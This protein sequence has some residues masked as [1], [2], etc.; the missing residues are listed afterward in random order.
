M[1]KE[2]KKNTV[3]Y[4]LYGIFYLHALLPLRA[5]Y[6]LSD[7]LYVLLYYLVRYRRKMVRKNLTHAFPDKPAN[8]ILATERKFY[9]FLCDYYVETIKLLH[10][11]DEEILRRMKFENPELINRITKGGNSCFLSLGHYGNWEFVP[12]I[13]YHLSPDVVQ[14]KIYKRL[15]NNGFEHFFLKLR[16]R[17]IPK[18]IE[19]KDAFRTIAKNKQEGKKMVI[20]F[21]TDQRPPRYYDEYWTT[22]LHQ[23]THVLTGMERIARQFGFAVVYLDIRRVKRGYYSGSFSLITPDASAEPE[24]AVMEKYMRKLEETILRDPAYWLWSHNRW[25]FTRIRPV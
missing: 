2:S 18:S 5:L 12:S 14:G 24:F 16:S 8:E 23:D 1:K 13:G 7:I 4:L 10:I 3:Y 19:M 9:R 25:K 17:F 22:F 6:V 20:G 15:N 11:S 21:V